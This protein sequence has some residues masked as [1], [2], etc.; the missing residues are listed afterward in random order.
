VLDSASLSGAEEEALPAGKAFLRSLA[1]IS[2]LGALN[3][4]P[5]SFS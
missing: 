3:S 5:N 2:F 1:G 4:Q